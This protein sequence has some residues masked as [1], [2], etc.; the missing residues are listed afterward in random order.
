MKD[1]VLLQ[2]S[3]LIGSEIIITQCSN[4]WW[5]HEALKAMRIPLTFVLEII[6][7]V[8]VLSS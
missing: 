6:L 8:T 1:R 5:F 3:W 2:I 4:G 7:D